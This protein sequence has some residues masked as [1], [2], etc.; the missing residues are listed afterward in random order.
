MATVGVE[1]LS[2]YCCVTELHKS[3]WLL[4]IDDSAALSVV[5]AARSV[6]NNANKRS[7]NYAAQIRGRSQ[8]VSVAPDERAMVISCRLSIV[9]IA[10]SLTI[11]RQFAVE[12]PSQFAISDPQINK[13]GHFGAKFG[14][15]LADRCMPDFNAI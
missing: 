9:T 7:L 14:E 12:L 4:P 1:G 6:N 11:R 5:S 13:C 8:G 10:L 3:A 15:E 2:L